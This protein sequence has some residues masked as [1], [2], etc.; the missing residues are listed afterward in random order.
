[1]HLGVLQLVELHLLELADAVS[2]V[3]SVAASDDS[4]EFSQVLIERAERN[5]SAVG[6]RKSGRRKFIRQ[7]WVLLSD[8]FSD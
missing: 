4:G 3:K 1:M 5:Y 8:K 2:Q 7:L 6:A